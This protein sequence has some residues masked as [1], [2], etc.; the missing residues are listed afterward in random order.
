MVIDLSDV[1]PLLTWLLGPGWLDGALFRPVV[2]ALV[3]CLLLAGVIWAVAALRKGQ[4]STSRRGGAVI[5]GGLTAVMILVVAGAVSWAISAMNAA[6]AAKQAAGT[7]QPAAEP[8]LVS[9]VGKPLVQLLGQPVV[10]GALYQWLGVM[11]CAAGGGVPDRLAADGPA[12]RPGFGLRRR[13]PSRRR[14]RTRSGAHLAAAGRGAG[15]AGRQGVD[16]P[17]G[18]GRAGRVRHH[19]ALRR[20]V[21]RPQQHESRAAVPGLRVRR[22]DAL[23]LA[24]A[25]AVPQ[26]VE[27]A[28]RHQEPHAAH[29]RDQA[30]AGQ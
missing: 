9:W 29:G 24:L 10:P 21:S 5:A 7:G 27:P 12:A 11:F 13:R 2:I 30:R 19:L 3:L 20:L 16:P 1:T 22:R 14:L 28:G 18:G 8:L 23:P 15:A 4:G 6:V 25:G 26:F 17:A